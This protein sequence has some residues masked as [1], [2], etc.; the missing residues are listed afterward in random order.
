[1]D[2]SN[3]GFQTWAFAVYL[4]TTSLKGASS[5][6]LHRDLRVTQRTA[7]HLA[8]RI[9]KAWQNDGGGLFAGPVEPDETYIGGK[10]RNKHSNKKLRAGRGPVGKTAVLGVK[11]QKTRAVS[12]AVV[13]NADKPTLHGFVRANV[14]PRATLYTDELPAYRGMREFEHRRIFSTYFCS[15]A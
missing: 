7:W 2:S 10:E 4:L 12:A 11:D 5:M 9:R 6:K 14:E 3:L 1:M 8:H 13:E 15:S